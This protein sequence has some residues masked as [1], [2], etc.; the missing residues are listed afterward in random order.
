MK[1]VRNKTFE[2]NSSS[3]H[4]ITFC[5]DSYEPSA[6]EPLYLDTEYFSCHEITS[7]QE[8]LMYAY[9]CFLDVFDT[10]AANAKF[11]YFNSAPD[12]VKKWLSENE[13]YKFPD[14]KKCSNN[15]VELYYK[16]Y[17]ESG[18]IIDIDYPEQLY[19]KLR[20]EFKTV[21]DNVI[22]AFASHDVKVIFKP[23][24]APF[25]EDKAR[26]PRSL[27]CGDRID[28]QSAPREDS[29]AWALGCFFY[30]PESLYQWVVDTNTKVDMDYDG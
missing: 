3:C 2:T 15:E 9:M 16:G 22:S 1:T 21:I 17:Y 6:R 29:D 4:S 7:W 20:H 19:E 30:N 10:K 8:K 26:Q 23:E 28:H 27:T 24:V 11:E 5:G 14:V 18:R 25:L 13:G 12:E